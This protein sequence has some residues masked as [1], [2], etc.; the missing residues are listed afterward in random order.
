MAIAGAQ[1]RHWDAMLSWAMP[2][3]TF[4][5]M[6]LRYG[7]LLL[8]SLL[9]ASTADAGGL[10]DVIRYRVPVGDG[11]TRGPADAPVTIVVF[12]D[13]GCRYCQ[14]AQSTLETLLLLYPGRVR[15]VYRHLPLDMEDGLVAAEAAAAAAAQG[16][17]WPM[18]DLLF[19][20]G[21][22]ERTTVEGLARQLGLDMARFRRELDDRAHRGSIASDAAVAAE[23]GLRSTPSIFINGRPVRGAQ[24]LAVFAR[25][26]EEELARSS[27]LIAT[28]VAPANVYETLTGAGRVR[29]DESDAAAVTELDPEG[30]YQVALG[31][32]GHTVGP[33]DALVT[34]TVFSDFECPFCARIVPSLQ[35][36]RH[37]FGDDV[38]IIFRHLPLPF[39][40]R[41]QLVSEAAVA[42]AA[43]G[44]F[45]PFH[46][47]VF[48]A[49]GRLDRADLE[50][51]AK[52][53]GLDMTAFRAALDERRYHDVVAADAAGGAA[54]GVTGTPTLFVNGQP[55]VGAA[56]Y[57]MLRDLVAEHRKRAVELVQGGVSRAD[58][59]A[60]ATSEA[61]AREVGDAGRLPKIEL[62]GDVELD[63]DD[64]ASAVRAACRARQEERAAALYGNL[65]GQQAEGARGD[66]AAY[67][68]DLR[69]A[70]RRQK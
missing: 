4:A 27:A 8:L 58:V 25:I 28:G 43:Q 59:Y 64:F 55:L 56:P 70:A 69:P 63:A 35:R 11:A 23:L 44:K 19:A 36:L 42:A 21:G 30:S 54:L 52:A 45:A 47:R 26:V 20:A 68:I 51:H 57:P 32:P 34:V 41:A 29:V 22:R 12:S 31:L 33:D 1:P 66:C 40:S 50:A 17:F 39:H 61:V 15:L 38:R 48:A 46:D 2:S 9:I 65:T 6:R 5:A 13:F 49:Q 16:Q 18:H 3:A 10:P 14:R 53:L 37:E 7:L 67:G 62:V 60:I 24:P